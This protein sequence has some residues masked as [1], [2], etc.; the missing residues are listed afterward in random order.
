MK[1]NEPLMSLQT[2]HNPYAFNIYFYRGSLL[3]IEEDL[4]YLQLFEMGEYGTIT[5]YFDWRGSLRGFGYLLDVHGNPLKKG[6]PRYREYRK[7]LQTAEE[8]FEILSREW[9]YRLRK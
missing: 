4:K 6:H 5:N 2:D 8:L 7:Y 9:R 3:G 1:I